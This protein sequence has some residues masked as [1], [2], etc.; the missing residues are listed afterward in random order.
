[1]ESL[2]TIKSDDMVEIQSK[3][4]KLTH[5]GNSIKVLSKE[6]IFKLID[7]HEPYYALKEVRVDEHNFVT[8]TIEAEQP[9]GEE[10]SPIA[11]AEACRH[12]AILGSV[13]CALT[14]PVKQKHYYL[15]HRGTYK[16]AVEKIHYTGKKL[17]ATAT[18]TF[19][20]KRI[21]SIKACLLDEDN[22]LICGIETSFHVV[23]HALFERLYYNFHKE[24]P[25]FGITNPYHQKKP[26]FDVQFSGL[27][28]AASLGKIQDNYCAGH[29][30]HF[31]AMPVA[32]LMNTLLDLAARYI[33]HITG[34]KSLKM[35]VREMT[36]LADNLGFSG[37]AVVL[38][39]KQEAHVDNRFK[40]HCIATSTDNKSVGDITVII[41]TVGA[42]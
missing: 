23:P 30:P 13:C 8:A 32:I 3:A 39:V 20:S 18:C 36:L 27:S 11:A 17:V 19:F 22:Q 33:H 7:V 14:N 31:P 1:M 4:I 41:E 9:L 28:A 37:E 34:N 6:E 15:A 38:H 5:T 16:R 42:L 29:F 24:T 21:A 40:L 10:I 25:D 2:Q 35:Y 26:L 12:L